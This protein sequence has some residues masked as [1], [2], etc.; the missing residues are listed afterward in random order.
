MPHLRAL[1]ALDLRDDAGLELRAILSQPKR[2]ALLLYLALARPRGFHRRDT[3]LALF[4]P[5]ADEAHARNALR[6]ALHHL[7]QALGAGVVTRR[8]E[9]V[10]LAPGRLT[11]DVPAFDEALAA[12]D[13]ERALGAYG[14]DLLPG[15]FVSGAPAF[16]R[17][18]EGERAR[19]RD[20]AAGAARTLAER[21]A[22]AGQTGSALHWARRAVALSADDEEMVRWCIALLGRIGD[23][24]AALRTY[25][26][27]VQGLAEEFDAEPSAE[28]RALGDALRVR[29][30]SAQ[31]SPTPPASPSAPAPVGDTAVGS[32]SRPRRHAVFILGVLA[33]AAMLGWRGWDLW[34]RA[35]L[36]GAPDLVAVFPF[37]VSGSEGLTYLGDVVATQLAGRLD[38]AGPRRSVSQRVLAPVTDGEPVMPDDAARGRT[39]AARLGAGQYVIGEIV[40]QAGRV[41]IRAAL[42]DR[43]AGRRPAVRAHAE[44]PAAEVVRLTDAIALQLLAPRADGAEEGPARGLT[45]SLPALRAYLRGE[46]AY[47]AGRYDDAVPWFEQAVALDSTFAAALYRLAV[48]AEWAGRGALSLAAASA[49]AALGD[50]LSPRQ[51]SLVEAFRAYV[52]ADAVV[53]EWHYRNLLSADGADVEAWSMLGETLFHYN[54]AR[55]R[56]FSAAREPFE[57]ALAL[58]P[59]NA[60]TLVHLVRLAA[61]EGRRGELIDLARRFLAVVPAGDRATEVRAILAYATGDPAGRRAVEAAMDSASSVQLQ[62]VMTAVAVFAR[63]LEGALGLARRFD[64][65]RHAPFWR[66]RG[67]MYRAWLEAARGR[68]GRAW[69]ELGEA[70]QLDPAWT[71]EVAATLALVP[72]NGMSAAEL[73]ARREQMQAWYRLPRPAREPPLGPRVI[74]PEWG[75]YFAGLMSAALGERDEVMREVDVLTRLPVTDETAGIGLQF[76]A[77]LRAATARLAGASW[78]G[79]TILEEANLGPRSTSAAFAY[80]ALAH[81]RMLRAALLEDVGRTGEAVEWYASFPSPSGFDLPFLAP[82]RLR[83]AALLEQRGD[84]R[85]AAECYREVVRLWGAGDPGAQAVVREARAG[86]RRVGGG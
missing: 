4:W 83:Q 28:T 19:V 58:E 63:D 6:Q 31:S 30:L 1:G 5:D 12:G 45:P 56:T 74:D 2:L 7:R 57:R 29:E 61:F 46:A 20:A 86:L 66:T 47:R 38:G 82:A 52:R 84:R 32:R 71:A 36:P 65:P 18:L 41:E 21:Q 9:D 81:E 15:F 53:A 17:W 40:A 68:W 75:A 25:E 77:A 59:G 34:G 50:R 43:G 79:L 76:A 60:N 64:E 24:T 54:A 72:G 42:Y 44:G 14:G 78:S 70:E 35:A 22:A 23:R 13:L 69:A 10:G 49:A 3:L 16:E 67:H 73:R 33:L 85:A 8:G 62:V 80:H 26:E 51:A 48:S 55:G 27:F 11:G 37:G 39:L